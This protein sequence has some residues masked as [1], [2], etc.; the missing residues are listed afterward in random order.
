MWHQAE[1]LLWGPIWRKHHWGFWG[2][3]RWCVW[4]VRAPQCSQRSLQDNRQSSGERLPAGLLN[5]RKCCTHWH[6]TNTPWSMLHHLEKANNIKSASIYFG[7][8]QSI[9]WR[10]VCVS[11]TDHQ[12]LRHG[13]C[14]IQEACEGPRLLSHCIEGGLSVYDC[15]FCSAAINHHIY[16]ANYLSLWRSTGWF[17]W[18]HGTFNPNT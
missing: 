18:Q 1:W 11:F 5:W 4:D 8:R 9:L 13:G 7:A 16:G 2:L 10:T 15:C 12:C 3:Y 14:Y 17:P 6:T